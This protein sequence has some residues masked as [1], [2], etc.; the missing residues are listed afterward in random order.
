MARRWPLVSPPALFLTGGGKRSL[1]HGRATRDGSEAGSRWKPRRLTPP[2]DGDPNS[3]VFRRFHGL[4]NDIV[5]DLGDRGGLSA[6]QLQL[7]RRCAWISAQCEAMEQRHVSGDTA[8]LLVYGVLTGHLA[9]AFR[10]I[11]L[12]RRLPTLSLT[13]YVAAVQGADSAS[14]DLVTA[15]NKDEDG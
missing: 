9:R 1:S 13:D 7:A 8:N 15:E 4:L 14:A 3:P 5:N 6:G 11:G 12:E 10:S 2:T